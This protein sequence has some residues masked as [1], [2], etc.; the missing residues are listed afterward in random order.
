M[1]FFSNTELFTDMNNA[2][3][4]ITCV[5]GDSINNKAAPNIVE[6]HRKSHIW[7]VIYYSIYSAAG[8]FRRGDKLSLRKL[9]RYKKLPP[10]EH[11]RM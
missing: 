6:R 2:S 9:S 5:R 8:D 1:K 10:E 3:S 7:H 11:V 4:T